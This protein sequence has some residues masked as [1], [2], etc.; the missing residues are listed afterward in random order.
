ML[1]RPPLLR[2]EVSL[3]LSIYIYLSI[4]LSASI[5]LCIY[6]FLSIFRYHIYYLPIYLSIYLSIYLHRALDLVGD[7]EDVGAAAALAVR[8]RVAPRLRGRRAP[9]PASDQTIFV[10]RLDLLHTSPD[11]GESLHRSRP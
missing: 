5:Y 7:A 3:H 6:R 10:T 9:L 11:S 8:G 1:E 4:Y 2:C